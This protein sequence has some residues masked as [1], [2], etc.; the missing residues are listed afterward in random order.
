MKITGP[1][2]RAGVSPGT[3]SH[4]LSGRRPISDATRR[5]SRPL[6]ASPSICPSPPSARP[7]SRRRPASRSPR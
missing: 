2:R 5:G 4:A 1:A 3:V 6:C 7:R